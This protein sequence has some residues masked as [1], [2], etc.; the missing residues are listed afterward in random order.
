MQKESS[1][2][3]QESAV[4]RLRFVVPKSLYHLKFAS[5]TGN[6]KQASS[7]RLVYAFRDSKP[8]EKLMSSW[9]FVK[10]HFPRTINEPWGFQFSASRTG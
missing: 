1:R 6:V 3:A 2:R 9:H 4:V 10:R 8:D 7:Q 5:I